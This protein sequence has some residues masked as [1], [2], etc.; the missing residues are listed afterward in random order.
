MDL[1]LKGGHVIDGRN[2]IDAVRDLAITDGC[3]ATVAPDIDPG[4]ARK[5][6]DVSGL[7]V[8]PGLVDLHMH[9]YTYP[10]DRGSCADD[11]CVMPDGF[12]FRVGVT[13]VVDAGSSGW[14]NFEDFKVRIIDRSRTR[15]LVLLN[16]VGYGKGPPHDQNLD[17]MD[18]KLTTQMA[19]KHMD[20]V[21]GIKTADFMG[22]EWK[23]FEQAAEAGRIANIPVM[24]DFGE[25]RKER[26]LEDL[27]TKLLR[28]GDI[29]THIYSDHRGQTD[30]N[31]GPGRVILDGRKRG[32]LFDLGHGRGEFYWSVALPM[33]KAGFL[34]DSFSTDLHSKSMNSG[35]KDML[36]VLGKFLAMG[37]P[38]HAAILR[39]TWNPAKAIRHT[40]LGNLSAGS[41]ADVAVLRLEKG[42]YGFVDSSGTRLEGTQKLTCELT[43]RDGKVVYDLNGITCEPWRGSAPP[44]PA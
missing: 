38:L 32:V 24:L 39:A 42:K 15:V 40:E 14:R 33:M 43:L 31:G 36:N 21:C 1:L 2:N 26:S 4:T 44:V 10:G 29:F 35:M 9:G 13:T 6:V 5:T 23:P 16:I 11:I 37:M 28:P 22:P 7:Y 8:T 18:A 20:V 30:S 25:L 12:T 17:D 27:F 3:I 19:L 41:P 34:P